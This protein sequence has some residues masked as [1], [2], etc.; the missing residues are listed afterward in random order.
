MRLG[1]GAGLNLPLCKLI[2]LLQKGRRRRFLAPL[3]NNKQLI[4]WK[5]AEVDAE[6]QKEP[7]QPAVNGKRPSGKSFENS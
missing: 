6:E 5:P 3:L 4:I 7:H 2:Y 1:C